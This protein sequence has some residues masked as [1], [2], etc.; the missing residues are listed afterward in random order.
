MA[1]RLMGRKAG[2]IQMF[3]QEG[4]PVACTVIHAEPSVITQI[5]TQEVDGY[6]AI[7]LGYDEVKTKDPRT[8][9]KRCTKQL[10]GH[11]KKAGVAPRRFLYE[12]RVDGTDAYS[13]GQKFDVTQFEGASH[14]DITGTSKGKGY[15][16]VMKKYGFS[17]G[18]ASHGSGFHRHAG[19]TGMRSTPGRCLPGGPRPSHMGDVQVT[20]QSLR[21]ISVDSEKNVVI[22][23]GA[24]PGAKNGVVYLAEAK[25]AV[26]K[27]AP[28]TATKKK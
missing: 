7:Q 12:I 6:Q 1:R 26:P 3:D 17:G 9:E 8:V 24:V 25:K 13:I 11:Y 20:V 27:K 2:M 10:L 18:P 23:E 21:V 14:V 5:K 15:Q 28:K 4:N 22:V 19:S 16:G